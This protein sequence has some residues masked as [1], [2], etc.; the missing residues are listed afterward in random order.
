MRRVLNTLCILGLAQHAPFMNEH[1][2]LI[3]TSTIGAPS[4]GA[5]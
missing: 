5:G 3:K 2:K 1:L 4:T